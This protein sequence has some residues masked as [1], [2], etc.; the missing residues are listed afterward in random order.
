[1]SCQFDFGETA[2]TDRFLQIVQSFKSGISHHPEARPRER[3][4][5]NIKNI[6]ESLAFQQRNRPHIPTFL[7]CRKQLS[8]A[9]GDLPLLAVPVISDATY[10]EKTERCHGPLLGD[11]WKRY[12]LY[13]H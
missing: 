12:S 7:N 2:A 9:N 5:I 6:S 11:P 8:A 13:G 10:R 4:I 1:M 3:R